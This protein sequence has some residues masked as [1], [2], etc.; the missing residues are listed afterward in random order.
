[1]LCLSRAHSLQD[2]EDIASLVWIDVYRQ[3]EKFGVEDP[4]G[5]L[6]QLVVWRTRDWYRSAYFSKRT[7]KPEKQLVEL[8]AAMNPTFNMVEQKVLLEQ[9]LSQ[10]SEADRAMLFG[11]FVEELTWE[12]LAAEFQMHRN[13]VSRRIMAVLT[14]VRA[15]L[16]ETAPLSNPAQASQ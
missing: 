9:A 14:R 15:L 10:E 13:T 8:F 6:H 2:A 12:E 11:R 16:E 5:L 4:K 3:F 1:M 7:E